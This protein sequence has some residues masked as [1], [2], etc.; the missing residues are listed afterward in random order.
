MISLGTAYAFLQNKSHQKVFLKCDLHVSDAMETERKAD[1]RI[2]CTYPIIFLNQ[3][4][5][6]RYLK[7]SFDCIGYAI[8]MVQMYIY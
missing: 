4:E 8:A 2:K 7:I 3:K 5:K 6:H 1:K